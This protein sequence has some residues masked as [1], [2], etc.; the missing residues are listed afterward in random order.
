MSAKFR[1]IAD[2]IQRQ[3]ESWTRSSGVGDAPA[4]LESIPARHI[5]LI[6]N[7]AAVK[8]LLSKYLADEKGFHVIDARTFATV[9]SNSQPPA[10]AAMRAGEAKKIYPQEYAALTSA[11]STPIPDEEWLQFSTD[12]SVEEDPYKVMIM[13][14]EEILA[15][16]L[17]CPFKLDVV[18]LT[19]GFDHPSI[20]DKVL[21][22]C[23]K[24]NTFRMT[25]W[26]F[27]TLGTAEDKL[28]FGTL[29]ALMQEDEFKRQTGVHTLT[30][31]DLH[32]VIS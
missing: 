20:A 7:H 10:L 6:T 21:S 26:R 13:T 1:S 24:I 22:K 29:P 19:D 5:L 25:V 27:A 23:R 12:F 4:T 2:A 11:S 14:V 28:S 8:P 32:P 17:Q 9:N 30:N 3:A 31:H 16:E 18:G 15:G